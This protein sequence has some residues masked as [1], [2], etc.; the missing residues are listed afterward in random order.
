MRWLDDKEIRTWDLAQ[1]ETLRRCEEKSNVFFGIDLAW[2]DK[3]KEKGNN[4]RRWY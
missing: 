3:V 2:E 4:G 1:G